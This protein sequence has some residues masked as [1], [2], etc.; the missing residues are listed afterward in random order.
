MKEEEADYGLV[1][2]VDEYLSGDM[3]ADDAAEF[4]AHLAAEPALL[5][6]THRA[7]VAI[8]E[9]LDL[10]PVARQRVAADRVRPSHRRISARPLRPFHYRFA[11]SSR[12]RAGVVRTT[13]GS[14]PPWQTAEGPIELRQAQ[15]VEVRFDRTVACAGDTAVLISVEAGNEYLA[16]V[17]EDITPEPGARF[18]NIPA[19]RYTLEIRPGKAE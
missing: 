12:I 18:E 14:G 1:D 13:G 6:K 2:D 7:A 4:L 19:G 15:D 5:D 3:P 10:L 8:D 11:A 17:E 9:A 16:E